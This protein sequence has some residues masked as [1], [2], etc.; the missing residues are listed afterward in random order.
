LRVRYEQGH[1]DVVSGL[2]F[3]PDGRRLA[4]FSRDTLLIHDPKTG[5]L[6]AR[7]IAHKAPIEQIAFSPD[8]KLLATGGADE[9][10]YLWPVKDFFKVSKA[11]QTKTRR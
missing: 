5:K 10:V 2:A 9:V 7:W 11:D 6:L 8:G 1:C 3:A 4:S